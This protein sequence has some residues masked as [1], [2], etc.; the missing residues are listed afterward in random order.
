MLEQL[1]QHPETGLYVLRAAVAVIFAVHGLPKIKKAKSMASGMGKPAWFVALLG[2]A[3]VGSAL[4]LVL[5]SGVYVAY[6]S[7]LLA[8]IMLG[9]IYHKLFKWHVPFLGV[10]AL[11]WEFD[12]ILLAANL[13]IAFSG[14]GNFGLF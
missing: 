3:E 10:S 8:I 4:V 7:L 11:G 9:A 13:A 1:F 5:S 12:F 6:A 2:L 14:G